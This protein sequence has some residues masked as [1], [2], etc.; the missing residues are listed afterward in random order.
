MPRIARS[1]RC[2]AVAFDERT[3]ARPSH[4]KKLIV[5]S[6][7]KS[8]VEKCDKHKSGALMN[9]EISAKL[10]SLERIADKGWKLQ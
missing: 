6:I 5:R 3:P 7:P 1:A 2:S 10:L 9:A 4:R 8:L